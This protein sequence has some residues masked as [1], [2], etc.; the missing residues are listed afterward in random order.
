MLLSTLSYISSISLPPLLLS[1]SLWVQILEEGMSK[2]CQLQLVLTSLTQKGG[3][4]KVDISRIIIK[5]ITS[6]TCGDSIETKKHDGE[7]LRRKG[8]LHFYCI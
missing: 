5:T 3:K 4:A 1:S 2:I 6:R 8:D 7:L